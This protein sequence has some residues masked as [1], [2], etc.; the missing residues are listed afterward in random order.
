M[1]K[2]VINR[3]DLY[4]ALASVLASK[5]ANEDLPENLLFDKLSEVTLV[6]PALP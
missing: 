1:Q 4:H 2:H 5:L 6:T 3:H